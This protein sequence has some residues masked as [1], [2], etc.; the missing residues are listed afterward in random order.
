MRGFRV[1]TVV[2]SKAPTAERQTFWLLLAVGCWHGASCFGDLRNSFRLDWEGPQA[3]VR[4]LPTST[5]A[6]KKGSVLLSAFGGVRLG[7]MG[8]KE[9]E[10]IDRAIGDLWGAMSCG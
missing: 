2:G 7:P 10:T 6:T 1:R 8:Q 9:Y 3:H 5:F 4:G